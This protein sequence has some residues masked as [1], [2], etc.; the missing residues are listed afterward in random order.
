MK[1]RFNLLLL[2]VITLIQLN[3]NAQNTFPATGSAGIGTTTPSASS[4]FEMQSTSKGFLIPRMTQAQRD[5][6][7]S[8]A[9]SLMIYQTDGTP[10]FYYIYSGSWI[11]LKGANKSLSDLKAPT[12]INVDLLPSPTNS[13]SLGSS[14]ARWKDVNL[15]NLKFAD[16][17]VQTSAAKIYTAGTGISVSGNTIINA[18]PD[19]TVSL[20]GS[21]ATTVTGTYP[22]FTILSTDNNTTYTAGTGINISGNTISSTVTPSQ[23]TTSGSSIYYNSGNVGIGTTSPSAKLD[24]NGDALINGVNIGSGT[25]ST[26]TVVGKGALSSNTSGSGNTATGYSSLGSN[27]TGSGNSSFGANS[28]AFNT[29]S[30]NTGLGEFSLYSNNTGNDNTATGIFSLYANTYG[31][32]NTATGVDALQN[33]STGSYNTGSGSRSLNNNTTGTD[34]TANGYYSLSSNTNGY[35]NTG[36]GYNALR[37][38]TSGEFNTAVGSNSLYSGTGNYN[39]SVGFEAL[40]KNATYDNTAMGTFSLEQNTTGSN[41]TSVGYGS[42]Y[43]TQTT[44]YCSFFGVS[45]GAGTDGISNSTAIG[46]A[47]SVTAS[48]QVRVG[49]ASITSIGGQVGWTTL[50]DG[51]YKKNIQQ[52]VPGLKFI[53][54]LTPVTY[55]LDVNK[56]SKFFKEDNRPIKSGDQT[57]DDKLIQQSRNEKS[58][59]IY[60]GFI[61][62]D[63]EAVA[64]KIH[65]DFSGVDAPDSDSSTYGLRYDQFVVPLVKAVQ[66]LSKMNNAKDAS[67]DSL[68]IQNQQLSARLDK[69]EAMLASQNNTLPFIALNKQTLELSNDATL[70]QNIPNPF[71]KSTTISYNLPVNNGNAYINFYGMNGALLK[72]V[73]L[74][75]NGK[76]IITLKANELASG[77]Y[78]YTLFVDG[79]NIDSKQMISSK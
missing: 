10:G 8:P 36:I 49:N 18:A 16:S 68:K 34:N 3:L 22:N 39:T 58:K 17:T 42:A 25:G 62:Q 47:S 52:N 7:P 60:T 59:I 54:L 64:K 31:S 28:L 61:A 11:A 69:I 71:S 44:S 38:N 43:N 72:S 48:N 46:N 35:D 5:A 74:A 41:N 51:R 57:N 63:V 65:Y 6:I 67:I 12:A 29:G 76:G 14:K 1:L 75:D 79:K 2:A 24:V 70:S 73:K 37:S 27:T 13:H 21:G 19:Q 53:N 26:N 40:Y 32:E 9:E 50:S 4:L 77:T 20:T 78:L 23:W 30:Y 66:E 56:L 15:Y 45:S 55:N 33:N